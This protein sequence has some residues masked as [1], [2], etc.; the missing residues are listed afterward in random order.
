MEQAKQWQE[1]SHKTKALRFLQDV[2]TTAPQILNQEQSVLH[3]WTG[4]ES[5]VPDVQQ[6]VSFRM[7]LYL[8]QLCAGGQDRKDLFRRIKSAYTTRSKIAHGSKGKFT[9]KDWYIAW[10]LLRAVCQSI[11]TRSALPTEEELINE[12]LDS[13]TTTRSL[14]RS[15]SSISHN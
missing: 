9:P 5:L 15:N 7:A 4:L 13:P 3:I 6:E 10:D 1:L 11:L 8:A 2:L 12:L 14:E